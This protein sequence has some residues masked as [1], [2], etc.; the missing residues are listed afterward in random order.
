MSRRHQI[1]VGFCAGCLGLG[2]VGGCVQGRPQARRDLNF[3]LGE[4]CVSAKDY[5]GAVRAFEASAGSNPRS[6]AA[7]LELGWLEE[8]DMADPAVAIYHY[9]QYLKL[10][11]RAGNTRFV[12]VRIAACKRAVAMAVMPLPD[13][14]A[15]QRQLTELM[16]EHGRL[17]D[18]TRRLQ[19]ELNSCRDY[20]RRF[21]AAQA[22]P[23]PQ[24]AS[25]AGAL[26]PSGTN[27]ARPAEK[28]VVARADRPASPVPRAAESWRNYTVVA[29]DMVAV[30]ARRHG[31]S[32]AALL[33]AN[34]GLEPRRMMVG[35]VLN[36]PVPQP[37]HAIRAAARGNSDGH[38]F[39]RPAG[40]EGRSRDRD[41][42]NG[43]GRFRRRIG[44]SGSGSIA[45]LAFG[46][47]PGAVTRQ[48]IGW[49]RRQTR[50]FSP[51]AVLA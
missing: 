46:V 41:A 30:I 2:L 12:R 21:T 36:L 29:G 44:Q 28:A 25:L 13:M 14:P 38:E 24:A 1:C 35:R 48:F 10:Q 47:G 40:W 22:R 37:P 49:K 27:L 26:Q 4:K 6:A 23:V 50:R 17:Q 42:R 33:A 51:F 11:P 34:P 31:I 45:S 15:E 39:D 9:E 8:Q 20:Y 7:Q 5:P 3:A 19:S 43:G 32:P 18:E 16:A